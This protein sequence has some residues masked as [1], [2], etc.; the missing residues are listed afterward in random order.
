[1]YTE[2]ED[3]SSHLTSEIN[4]SS[5]GA[6]TSNRSGHH[7]VARFSSELPRNDLLSKGLTPESGLGSCTLRSRKST[8]TFADIDTDVLLRHVSE[9]TGSSVRSSTD[10]EDD[11][12]G[13]TEVIYEGG[14][15]MNMNMKMKHP[16]MEVNDSKLVISLLEMMEK[17]VQQLKSRYQRHSH[18]SSGG[19]DSIAEQQQQ[20]Q[21]QQLGHSQSS[22][23]EQ[24]GKLVQKYMV[25]NQKVEEI[26]GI[27][28][29]DASVKPKG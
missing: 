6:T 11:C 12:Y 27:Q 25:I 10:N 19:N 22:S 1:M 28:N 3:K 26:L 24:D 7:P 16:E 2:T 13:D 23:F 8:T 15:A 14:G 9:Y 21:Q 5:D 17:Q 18:G 29:I 20:Q 4:G